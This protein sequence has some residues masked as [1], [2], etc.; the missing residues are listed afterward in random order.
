M[1]GMGR[2]SRICRILRGLPVMLLSSD[3]SDPSDLS[4]QDFTTPRGKTRVID[5]TTTEG[6]FMSLDLSP[7][8]QWIAF[9][10]LGH[11]Y[12]MPVAGGTATA[13][14]QNTGVALNFDPAIAPDGRSIA[15]I[16]DRGGQNNVWVMGADG[17]GARCARS[18]GRKRTH[19]SR[20]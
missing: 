9:D 4:A 12:R 15:F 2:M 16:S 7:D 11:I 18:S 5:F 19:A 3:L 8:G 20:K 13:I 17:T 1:S 10:L 6:T 14:T